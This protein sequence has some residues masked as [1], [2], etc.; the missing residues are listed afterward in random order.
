MRR[1]T[2]PTPVPLAGSESELLRMTTELDEVHHDLSLPA[3]RRAVVQ[4]TEEVRDDRAVDGT[5]RRTS[6][7]TF[8][9]GS[10]ALAAGGALLAACGSGASTA[11]AARNAASKAA[12]RAYPADLTGDLEVAALA[13]S[14]ENLGVSAYTAGIDAARAGKLG[15]VPPAV[16]TFATTARSQHSQHAAAWNAVLTGAGKAKVT[17]PDPALVPTVHRELAAVT[18]VSGL[19]KL[20]LTIEDIAAQTYQVATSAL[21]SSKAVA[22]AASIQPV[23]LQHAAILRFVLGDYPVPAAFNPTSDARPT[24]D[25]RA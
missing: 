5:A 23:E 8:L 24:S 15:A 10:G 16:L 2:R 3:L 21:R 1:R 25:L 17:E 20:A 4:L 6:R 11:S 9:L 18:D 19:A 12:R 13:A 7:R 14:L 22:T